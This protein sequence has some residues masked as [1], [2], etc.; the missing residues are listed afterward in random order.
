MKQ[1]YK[2][3]LLVLLVLL[4]DQATKFYIKTNFALNDEVKMFGLNWARLHFVENKGMAFG[5]EFNVTHGEFDY[6]KLLLS[7]FRIL[8]V[9]GLIWYTRMLLRVKAPIGF[10]YCIGL[11][12]AGALGN[13][14]DSTFY[15]LIF[16]G[17][18][19]DDGLATLAPFGQGYGL[20]E[21]LPMNGFL[22]GRVVD[23]FY[24]PITTITLPE[25]LGGD[26]FLFFSPIFNVADASIT[27]GI[28]SI[29]LFQ[30][31]FFRDGFMD[32]Q[33]KEESVSPDMMPEDSDML[34][35][36]EQPPVA[37]LPDD[38]PSADP[39]GTDGTTA[40]DTAGEPSGNTVA[41]EK[42]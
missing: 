2:V 36:P 15:A 7:V 38:E 17:G 1:G 18:F 28:L 42:G 5:I 41:D 12:T 3:A 8:M 37:E 32:E 9:A 27:T 29:L 24:F 23:M 20:A 13:I 40:A 21:G 10:V 14:I 22:H 30:R 34:P 39:S 16:T 31:R 6:G 19:H 35:D 25:W 26:S 33:K 4:I 11:I